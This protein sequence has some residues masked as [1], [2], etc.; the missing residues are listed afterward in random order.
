MAQRQRGTKQT[1]SPSSGTRFSAPSATRAR[2]RRTS[3]RWE[4]ELESEARDRDL[5]TH[6]LHQLLNEIELLSPEGADSRIP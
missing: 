2:R 5:L 1:V 6:E 4:E 3:E